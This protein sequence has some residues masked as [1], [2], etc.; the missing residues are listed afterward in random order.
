MKCKATKKEIKDNY[1]K[2]I[3]IGYCN[4]EFL[5]QYKKP[6]A[7]SC[8]QSGWKC[9]YYQIENICISTGYDYL[10]TVKIDYKLVRKYEKQAEKIVLNYALDYEKRA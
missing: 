5:L 1:S 10:S 7:Y 4:V 6:F 3:G 8:G 9:D 2:V